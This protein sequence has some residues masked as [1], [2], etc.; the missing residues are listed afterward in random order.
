MILAKEVN[1]LSGIIC[2]TYTKIIKHTHT[3]CNSVNQT[4]ARPVTEMNTEGFAFY[5]R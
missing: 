5:S 4:C 2:N 1:M 3:V